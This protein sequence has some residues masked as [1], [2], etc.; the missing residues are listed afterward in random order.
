MRCGPAFEACQQST[1]RGIARIR[2]DIGGELALCL[3]FQTAVRVENREGE[4]VVRRRCPRR[5][6]RSFL[7][8][9]D[10]GELRPSILRRRGRS[11]T[12]RW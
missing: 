9:A 11:A 7:I 5:D 3:L 10:H 8:G 1:T 12:R 6:E 4:M 2:R